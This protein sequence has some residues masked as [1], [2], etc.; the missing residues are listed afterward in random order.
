MISLDD[1]NV[2]PIPSAASAAKTNPASHPVDDGSLISL[3][4]VSKVFAKTIRSNQRR[5]ARAVIRD[6]LPFGEKTGRLRNHEFKALD[7]IDLK[8]RRGEAVGLIG[9]NGAGKTTLLRILAGHMSADD[10]DVRVKG[11]VSD[12]IN[13]TAGYQKTLS[14]RENIFIGGALR[15]KSKRQMRLRYDD[16]VAFSEL[17]DFIEAPFGSY[18][19]GMKMRLGFSVAVHTDP[20]ILLIDEVL[21]VGDLRF[22]NKCLGRLQ[23]IKDQTAFVLVTHSMSQIRDFCDRGIFMEHGRIAFDGDADA[24]ADLYEQSMNGE[25]GTIRA[26]STTATGPTLKISELVVERAEWALDSGDRPFEEPKFTAR[27]QLSRELKTP[28]L[29]LQI[30]AE[31]GM[32]IT[33]L[34]D[35]SNIELTAI[36]SGSYDITVTMLN[37]RLNPGRYPTVLVVRDDA[38]LVFREQVCILDIPLKGGR[39]WGLLRT[40]SR[41][42][43]A[44]NLDVPGQEGSGEATQD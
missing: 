42:S 12:L 41:W 10:G 28:L 13:L 37:L 29:A 36:G 15:G 7:K 18:S 33:S 19:L 25:S 23:A 5:L 8:V 14:G 30:Y 35:P 43:A 32:K 11:D 24:A 9:H 40:A 38:E 26:E 39:P 20:D 22:R 2:G 4:G 21:G 16:I 6:L 3:T 31:D 1:I 34:S 44:I 27:L 17:G